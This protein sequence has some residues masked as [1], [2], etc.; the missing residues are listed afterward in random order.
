MK[1]TDKNAIE[2]I[3]KWGSKNNQNQLKTNIA[4]L[5]GDLAGLEREKRLEV[6]LIGL[7]NKAVVSCRPISEGDGYLI[8]DKNRLYLSHTIITL[9]DADGSIWSMRMDGWE[10]LDD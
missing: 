7:Y 6:G 4:L 5:K 2:E 9:I 3:T 1:T 10:L 8:Y